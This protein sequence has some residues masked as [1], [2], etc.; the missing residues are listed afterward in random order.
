[1]DHTVYQ[2]QTLTWCEA[3]PNVRHLDDC[4]DDHRFKREQ[5]GIA[6]LT[7][8]CVK[9]TSF[10]PLTNSSLRNDYICRTIIFSLDLRDQG[11][12]AATLHTTFFILLR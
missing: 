2:F 5:Q 3:L 10:D 4:L 6:T 1:M 12:E 11:G 9:V 8:I 7:S